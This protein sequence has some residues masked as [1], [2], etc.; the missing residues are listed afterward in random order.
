MKT[1]T[2]TATVTRRL[3]FLPR[4]ILSPAA[5]SSHGFGPVVVPD[6][7]HASVVLGS[8]QSEMVARTITT[9]L[10]KSGL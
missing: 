8:A 2:C 4:P 5:K 3:S 10:D 9:F 1:S 6:S 7:T